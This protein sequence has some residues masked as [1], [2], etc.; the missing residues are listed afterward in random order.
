M[1]LTGNLEKRTLEKV[2]S[3]SKK[4]SQLTNSKT[5]ISNS[6]LA[7]KIQCKIIDEKLCRN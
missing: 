4:V 5:H 2:E 3:S 7:T 1:E 6:L